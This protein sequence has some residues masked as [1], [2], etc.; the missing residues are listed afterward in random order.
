MKRRSGNKLICQLV[1]LSFYLMNHSSLAQQP[2]WAFYLENS[3][4]LFPKGSS[5]AS[6][7]NGNIYLTGT[8]SD[9][10]DMDPGSG[11]VKYLSPGAENIYVA[12]YSGNR[13]LLWS[14]SLASSL[15]NNT[16]YAYD[17]WSDNHGSVYITGSFTDSIDFDPGPAV[18]RLYPHMITDFFLAK[19]DTSGNFNWAF[20]LGSSAFGTIRGLSVTTDNNLNVIVTGDFDRSIDFDPSANANILTAIGD[21]DAFLASYTRNGDFRWVIQIGDTSSLLYQRTSAVCDPSGN[22]YWSGAFEY[23][24]DFDPGPGA[25]NLVSSGDLDVFLAKYDSS[26]NFLRAFS[27]GSPQLEEGNSIAIDSAYNIYIGGTFGLTVDF[28]PGPANYSLTSLTALNA[29]VAKYD[30]SFQLKW[31][32][33]FQSTGNS[34]LYELTTLNNADVLIAGNFYNTM[35]ADPSASAFY[36]QS[37]QQSI[38]GMIIQLDSSGLLK[39]VVNYGDIDNDYGYSLASMPGNSFAISGG[40]TGTIDLEPGSGSFLLSSSD[41]LQVTFLAKYSSLITSSSTTAKQD[42]QLV[43]FYPNPVMNE[44]TVSNST[45]EIIS[46]EIFSVEGKLMFSENEM[47]PGKHKIVFDNFSNGIYFLSIHKKQNFQFSKLVVNK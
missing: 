28:D 4:G 15:N 44:L 26:G 35:D 5:V 43:N 12:K 42:L 3:D 11:V 40:F 8:F 6:D 32:R 41:P 29:F 22:I 16:N 23:S 24:P 39:A 27:I 45:V 30:S 1:V 18:F 2:D 47:T 17:I 33:V 20:N 36:V 19:Y 46:F 31:A 37:I 25:Y 13:Q 7:L 34:F 38:D 9:T 10:I 14:F 21:E